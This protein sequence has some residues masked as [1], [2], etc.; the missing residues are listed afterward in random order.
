MSRTS[1]IDDIK[2]FLSRCRDIDVIW[3]LNIFNE[4]I[5]QQ[6]DVRQADIDMLNRI[7]K[8]SDIK[9]EIMAELQYVHDR[10][11]DHFLSCL[12]E[13]QSCISMPKIDLKSIEKN[14]RFILF[15]NA[16][17]QKYLGT[18][19]LKN[20]SNP[21]Y[22]FFYILFTYE[23]Y[24]DNP[25]SLEEISERFSNV[26]MKF[27]NHFKFANNEFYTWAN[28]YIHESEEYKRL[29]MTSLSSADFEMNINSIFDQLYDLDSNIH[30]ALRKKISN[31]WYQ[32]KHRDDK[33]VKKPGFYALTVKTKEALATLARKNN[34]SEDQVLEQLINK[35]YIQE[36]ASP[37]GELLY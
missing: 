17:M 1:A 26:Y 28:G 35:A 8:F 29:R 3:I 20:I 22:K 19:R 21:V 31:A 9:K 5:K 14:Q 33:K 34:L 12:E 36:C 32:K 15:A 23:E 27:N 10:D 13:H 7:N 4:E 6:E 2:S 37:I 24:F 18:R 16:I 25:R 11:I 30:Y